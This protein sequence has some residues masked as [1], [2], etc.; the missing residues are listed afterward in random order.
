M[1]D[2]ALYLAPS[3]IG[4]CTAALAALIGFLGMWRLDRLKHE[5]K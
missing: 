1:T 5:E 4:Q 3:T 2:A